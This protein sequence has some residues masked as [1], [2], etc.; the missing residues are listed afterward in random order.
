[1]YCP[2]CGV[3]N[4]RGE[5][6]CY[7]CGASLPSL[8]APADVAGKR[9]QSSTPVA[10]KQATVGDR[11]LAL[12]FD[13]FTLAAI[14]TIVLAATHM[15]PIDT[16]ATSAL[17]TM[18]ALFAGAMVLYHSIL[19]GAFGTTL[20]KAM[21]ALQVRTDSGRNRFVA[22]LLRNVLRIVDS[23]GFYVLGFL[24]A[25]FTQRAQRVGD[26]VAGTVVMEKAANPKVR[27]GLMLFWLVLVAVA[28]WFAWAVTP[29]PDLRLAR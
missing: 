1:M 12:I 13:R 22:A 17:A 6:N 9:R 10:E 2:Q 14:L 11:A 25:M 19:E 16:T 21:M 8:A 29:S 28:G 20:G 27:A 26:L 24:F 3:N 18:I 23:V 15:G 4:D 5:V 7:I